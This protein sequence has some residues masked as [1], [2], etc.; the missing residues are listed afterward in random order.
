MSLEIVC[1]DHG[2]APLEPRHTLDI[3]LRQAWNVCT[4]HED[5][6]PGTPC[7]GTYSVNP[8]GG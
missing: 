3:R 4:P 1:R 5:P 2:G 8:I 7:S 6:P